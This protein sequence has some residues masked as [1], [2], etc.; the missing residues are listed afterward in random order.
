[1]IIR[2]RHRGLR[3]MHERNDSS[4]L[5]PQ[6]IDKIEDILGRLD[7]ATEPSK[8]DIPGFRLHPLHGN[9]EG[10]WA[11]RVSRNWRITFRFEGADVTDVD[12]ADYH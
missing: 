2:I 4:Y 11:V 12:L 7:V 6:H 8:M 1:M 10:H 9:L 5:P 3:R